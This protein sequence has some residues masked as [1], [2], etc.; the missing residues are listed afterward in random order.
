MFPL[1]LLPFPCSHCSCKIQPRIEKST[2][3]LSRFCHNQYMCERSCFSGVRLFA[4]PWTVAGQALL[5]MG[6]PHK[7]TG[8]GG[9]ALL[10]TQVSNPCLLRLLH[11]QMVSFTEPSGKPNQR[12]MHTLMEKYLYQ[13]KFFLSIFFWEEKKNFL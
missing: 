2:E 3:L 9:H 13:G 11:Q 6:L 8:V 1:L 7:N 10:S 12:H 4:T 5:S